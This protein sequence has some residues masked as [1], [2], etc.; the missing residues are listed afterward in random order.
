MR[1]DAQHGGAVDAARRADGEHH[2]GL[3]FHAIG[4]AGREGVEHRWLGRAALV[5]YPGQGLSI[6]LASNCM[7]VPGD[8][9][10]PASEVADIFAG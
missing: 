4:P 10:G 2:L 5:I 8:V 9:L 7:V 3:H 1:M 6:A